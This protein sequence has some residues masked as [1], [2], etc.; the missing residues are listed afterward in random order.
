MS[1]SDIFR[2]TQSNISESL[3]VSNSMVF[4]SGDNDRL[5]LEGQD[6]TVSVFGQ[7]DF[8][9][10]LHGAGSDTTIHDH[11]TGT[12]IFM[13]GAPQD[14]TIFNFQTDPSGQVEVHQEYPIT[15]TPD[16]HGGTVATFGPGPGSIDFVGDKHLVAGGGVNGVFTINNA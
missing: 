5:F 16:G 10:M 14:M 1:N 8:V 7:R 2:L 13:L 15:L 4:V 3:Q 11:G 6:D 9:D 12:E